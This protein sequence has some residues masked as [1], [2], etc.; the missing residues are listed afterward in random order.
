MQLGGYGSMDLN[1]VADR[2]ASGMADHH[3]AASGGG[4]P[5]ADA[6]PGQGVSD[7]PREAARR[8]VDFAAGSIRLGSVLDHTLLN[9]GATA[10]DID[11]HCSEALRHRVAAVC[12]NPLWVSRCTECLRGSGVAVAS[13]IGFPFGALPAELKAAE[14]SLAVKHG[15]A[16]LDMVIPLGLIKAGDY[17][18]LHADIA[19][20]VVA[21]GDALVKVI[22]E[23]AALT[24]MEIMRAAT[25]AG[26]AGAHYV[27][28]S[29]GYSEA[30]GATAE[31]V[32]LLRLAVGDD[33]GVKASGGIRDARTAFHMLASG[34]TR[35]G[36]SS[37]A[38][39]A[40]ATGP[41][42]RRLHELM[43][44]PFQDVAPV[45]QPPVGVERAAT[46]PGRVAPGWGTWPPR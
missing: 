23:T 14:A 11:R 12:V 44:V 21:A 36:S 26:D 33:L 2:L 4:D 30:G 22:L 35:I 38:G 31:A 20:V 27:K 10:A 42:P 9:P 46:T 5:S 6:A 43:H 15:A 3:L 18:G 32:A 17:R 37:A 24:P 28:T 19:A 8:S 7:P 45:E 13:V 29:T 16:E 41:G 34:A 1:K 25:V 39:M 40:D